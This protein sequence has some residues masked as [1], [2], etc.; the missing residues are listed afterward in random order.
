MRLSLEEAACQILQTVQHRLP[1]ASVEYESFGGTHYFYIDYTGVQFTVRF[2]EAAL[3]GRN[4]TE[5]AAA[6][7]EILG[8]VSCLTP[9]APRQFKSMLMLS[10]MEST[11]PTVSRG[12]G[13]PTL[14]L[15]AR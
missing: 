3:H 11:R 4:K 5:L 1:L 14:P 12:A 2:S 15:L 6:I 13:E 8:Q 10:F 7:Q 9:Y